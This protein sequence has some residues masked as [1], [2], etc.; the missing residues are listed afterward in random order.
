MFGSFFGN[1]IEFLQN[2]FN[3]GVL[4]VIQQLLGVFG[5]G[6]SGQ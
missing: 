6:E 1:L 3:S 5:G 2:V 4:D